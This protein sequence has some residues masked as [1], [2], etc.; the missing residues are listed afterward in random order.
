PPLV[1]LLV[2]AAQRL[3]DAEWLMNAVRLATTFAVLIV[4][5]T[6]MGATLPVLVGARS[7]RRDGF[8]RALGRLYGWNTLGAVLGVLAAELVFIPRFGIAGSA[9]FAGLLNVSAAGVIL[10]VSRRVIEPPPNPDGHR[11]RE[12]TTLLARR[13]L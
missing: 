6:A 5:A 3:R 8:G 2:P 7:R 13:L 4:P 9:W 12:P 10:A 1:S 11:V